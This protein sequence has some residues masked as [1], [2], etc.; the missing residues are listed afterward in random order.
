MCYYKGQVRYDCSKETP[1]LNIRLI[2]AGVYML[3]IRLH[4]KHI[5]LIRPDVSLK[6]CGVI[7][8]QL[9]S[10]PHCTFTR[11]HSAPALVAVEV[12]YNLAHKFCVNLCV[13]RRRTF[14]SCY[15]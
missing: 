10:R 2:S 4:L 5:V 12:P 6:C 8:H 14:G 3:S 9:Y 1:K 15:L 13:N 7:A 11:T